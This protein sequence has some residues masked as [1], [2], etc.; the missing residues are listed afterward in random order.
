MDNALGT[1]GSARGSLGP[2]LQAAPKCL[3]PCC[4][5]SA[6]VREPC[7]PLLSMAEGCRLRCGVC[8]SRA[9]HSELTKA[10]QLLIRSSC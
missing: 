9:A 6:H 1:L 2:T 8:C 5:R 7:L 3:M 4:A 10:S